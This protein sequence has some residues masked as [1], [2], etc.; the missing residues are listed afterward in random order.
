MSAQRATRFRPPEAAKGEIVRSTGLVARFQQIR[1]EAEV[2]QEFPPEVLAEAERVAAQPL[3]LPQDDATDVPFLTVDPPGSM[4]LDQALHIERD[5]EGYR[6]R[7]AIAHL[8]SFVE[9]GGAIDAEAWRR[10]QTVYAPDT[11][12]P[13]HPP[14]FSEAAA[15]LLPDQVTPA[16]VWDLRLDGRGETTG[17]SVAPAMVRSTQRLDYEEVQGLVDGGTDDERLALLKEVGELRIALELER[18]GATLPMPEQVV[19]VHDDESYALRLRPLLPAEDW[20]AQISLMTG[21]AAA[22]LMLDAGV[23][24]LRTMPDPGEETLSRFRRVVQGLG[25]DWPAERTYGDFLRGLDREDPVHLA[26]IH[27]ATQLFRGAGY[28]AFDGEVPELVEQSAIAAPYA[29]VTAPLRRL[30]D[31]YGLVLCA[32]VSAG[33][34]VP[35][36][37]REALS[38]LPEVMAETDRRAGNVDRASTDAVEAAALAGELGSVHDAVVVDVPDNGKKGSLEV[39]LVDRPI[40]A[41]AEGEADLGERVRVMVTSAEIATGTIG[42]EVTRVTPEGG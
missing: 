22:Q 21:M 40:I 23:G 36:W 14:V 1:D 9:P 3:S 2:P 15:S 5:G 13:L 8:P 26:L 28:T 18:G 17:I 39:Q 33:E 31:R 16:Y 32:A 27:E 12:V 11:R 10:G 30:V 34:E 7:Y 41:R 38:R 4:D 37:V 42:L 29:H 6:V 24:V 19:E 20:N 35:G 25:V